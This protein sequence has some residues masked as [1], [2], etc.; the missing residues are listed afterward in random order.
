MHS[1]S[2]TLEDF[3]LAEE[4]GYRDWYRGLQTNVTWFAILFALFSTVLPY[5]GDYRQFL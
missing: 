4:Y 5:F 1:S 2:K 3:Y